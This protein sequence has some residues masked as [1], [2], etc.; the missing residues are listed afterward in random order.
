MVKAFSGLIRLVMIFFVLSTCSAQPGDYVV[1]TLVHPKIPAKVITVGADG[2]DIV[3]FTGREVQFAI[4]LLPGEGG[5]VEMT[6]GVF[7]IKAPIR[8]KS[9]VRLEGAGTETILKIGEGVASRFIIDADFGELKVTVEDP[10][11][12]EPGMALQ[13]M[14]ENHSSCW[15]V[16]TARITDIQEN[17]IYFDSGLVRDYRS[18]RNGVVSNA[19]SAVEVVEAENVELSGFTVDGNRERSARMDGCRGA[20]V[21]VFKSKNVLIDNLLVTDC[22]GEGISWQ[23]TED[24]TVRH[25]EI[26]RSANMGM[27]P[28]TGSPRTV[29]ENNDVHHNDVDGLFICWRVHHSLVKGNHFHNNGR[30][31]ICNGH[32][33]TDILFEGN[34]IYENG[35]DGVNFRRERASN[36]PHRATFLNN[37]V[38]NNGGAGFAFFSPA[39]NVVLKENFIRDTGRG[40]QEVGIVVHPGALPVRLEDNRISGHPEGDIIFIEGQ[41]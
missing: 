9:N 23:I 31:G 2:S 26:R 30:F 21:F 13:V 34:K 29:I 16:S 37:L 27:H 5:K 11:G 4:D 40:T 20:G 14:D 41:D 22:N 38:E 24:V 12:F 3:G 18:D 33:D 10:T 39:E 6:E 19:T 17:I 7:E 28:G 1:D 8:V 35:S 36:A 32:K 15:A 25:C